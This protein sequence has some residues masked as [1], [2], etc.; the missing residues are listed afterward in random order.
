[1]FIRRALTALLLAT[2][3]SAPSPARDRAARTV[4]APRDTVWFWF[5]AC[6][7]PTMTLEVRLDNTPVY[8]TSFPVCHADRSSALSQGQQGQAGFS[9]EPH[10]LL[11]WTGYRDETD[12][13]RIHQVIDGDLWQ[14]G[15][16]PGA[17]L[18]GVS[19]AA[20]N[21]IVMNTIHIVRPGASDTTRIA[22][23][24]V[25]LSYPERTRR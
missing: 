20:A 7:G 18:L 6:G 11:V 19:F 1:M 8:T 14:A 10:R 13:T 5:A 3:T 15:A 16:D 12:T 17:L 4:A 24:L 25:V 23:G 21:R 22:P 9:F 2:S